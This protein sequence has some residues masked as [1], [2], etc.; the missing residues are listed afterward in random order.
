MGPTPGVVTPDI[1]DEVDVVDAG[2]V[3]QVQQ[4]LGVDGLSSGSSSWMN[5]LIP[6]MNQQFARDR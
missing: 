1:P 4:G 5:V 2:D 3:D 6:W